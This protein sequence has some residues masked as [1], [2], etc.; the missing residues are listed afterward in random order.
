MYTYKNMNRNWLFR[1]RQII[2]IITVTVKHRAS[3]CSRAEKKI[4]HCRIKVEGRLYSVGTTQFESLV[5]LVKYYERNPLY[6]KIKLRHPV[7]EDNINNNFS[8]SK[9]CHFYG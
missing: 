7:S 2:Q 5:E 8:V 1:R 9:I 6:K 3:V 4:K